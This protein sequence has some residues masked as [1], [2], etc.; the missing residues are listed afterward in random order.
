[1][2]QKSAAARN[3]HL[4]IER[5]CSVFRAELRAAA[6]EHDLKLVQLEALIYLSVANRYSDTAGAV[7]EYLGVTKGSV[8]QSLMALERQGL[9]R[10]KADVTDRRVHHCLV[11]P[12]GRAIARNAHPAAFL[13]DVAEEPL[14]HARDAAL[15][16]LRSLQSA[17]EFRTFGQCRT[18]SQFIDHGNR[19][20]CGLTNERLTNADSLRICR[21]HASRGA[22]TE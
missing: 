5:V 20:R 9:I 6:V 13:N 12:A 18:C 14:K 10:K 11:T 21:E 2:S 1:M 15:A 19:F 7:G 8:S 4:T 16:L 3:L 17:T 22:T